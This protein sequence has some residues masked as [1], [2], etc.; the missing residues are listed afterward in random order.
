MNLDNRIEQAISQASGEPV[1]FA[2][3]QHVS[4]GSINVSRIVESDDGRRWF[5][6]T[7][8]DANSYPGMFEAE[9]QGLLLLGSP[10]VIRVPRPLAYNSDFIVMEAYTES[11][12]RPDWQEL[13]G[14]RLALLHQATRHDT[15]GFERDNY[16]G[17]TLQPNSWNENWIDFWSK[18]RLGWQLDLFAPRTDKGD[19][20]LVM[21][22]RLRD[23]LDGLLG[24][25]DESAVLLHGDLWSGNVAA[26]E[27]GEPVIFDPACYYGRREAEIGMMRLFGGFG[28]RCEAA[29]G[30]VWPLQP[31]ADRRI[32]L[33]RL[34]HELN[35]LNLF[36]SGYYNSC[37]STMKQ[38]F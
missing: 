13:M 35:H 34:Y 8:P 28:P 10:G 32:I 19:P 25:D 21:G 31:G 2:R 9:Y 29:Y 11:A 27:A 30:E 5:V 23:K 33:Y 16:L 7:H 14:R 37:I 36:G 4:G 18:H 17:T 6:K 26:D 38:L 20:L 24:N 15:Y 22:Y 1:R 12:R 3:S